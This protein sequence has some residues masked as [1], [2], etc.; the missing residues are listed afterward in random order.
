MERQ[1]QLMASIRQAVLSLDRNQ[2]IYDIRTM[3]AG[4]AA[5][6]NLQ[7]VAAGL[8]GVFAVVAL[9]LATIGIYGVMSYVVSQRTHEIGIRMAL[10]AQQQDVVR[11]VVGRGAWMIAFGLAIGALA[12]AGVTQLLTDL[13]FGISPTDPST[14]AGLAAFLATVALVAS[15]VPARRAARVDPVIALR[16]E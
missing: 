9:I 8:C 2:P 3:R 15:Y 4:I 16:E 1:G 7:Q 11:M 12:A 10:G 6:V 5:S 14:F 13:L